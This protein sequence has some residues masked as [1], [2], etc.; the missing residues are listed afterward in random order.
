M[1]AIQVYIGSLFDKEFIPTGLKTALFVGSALFLI[2]HGF[3]FFRGEMN[4]ERWIS[5]GITYLM[6]YLV[7][8]YGQHAYRHKLEQSSA[9]VADLKKFRGDRSSFK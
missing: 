9:R 8:V 3:A 2:N 6:P 7:S 5:V 4:L 1:K